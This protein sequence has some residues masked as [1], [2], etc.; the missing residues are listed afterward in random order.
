MTTSTRVTSSTGRVR[1]LAAAVVFVASYFVAVFA[2]KTGHWE[3][4]ALAIGYPVAIVLAMTLG[5]LQR[6]GLTPHALGDLRDVWGFLPWPYFAALW[7][8][9]RRYR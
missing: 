4:A 8:I 3:G 6:E 2:L 9:R 7:V 5:L 1:V